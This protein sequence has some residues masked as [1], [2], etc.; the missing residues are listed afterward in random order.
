MALW[1]P[2]AVRGAKRQ[3]RAWHTTV[4]HMTAV[5]QAR[6][7]PRCVLLM[8]GALFFNKHCATAL[9][10]CRKAAGIHSRLPGRRDRKRSSVALE[11]Q[12]NWCDICVL[13]AF[14]NT[15]I[16][17]NSTKLAVQPRHLLVDQWPLTKSYEN[18][19]WTTNNHWIALETNS[20][21]AGAG[22]TFL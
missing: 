12:L 18:K 19:S 4:P 17:D 14:R 3:V 20:I 16:N 11:S 8:V 10:W 21:N 9:D 22:L 15:S 2:A 1:A 5:F 7:A 13:F 6:K